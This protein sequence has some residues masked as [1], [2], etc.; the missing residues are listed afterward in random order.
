VFGCDC[1]MLYLFLKLNAGNFEHSKHSL[2]MSNQQLISMI[3]VPYYH[4]VGIIQ[5]FGIFV[6]LLKL[7]ICPWVIVN[8][9]KDH[10]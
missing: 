8:V 9:V 3:V 7:H 4:D 2:Q 1:M 5:S 6:N 10:H